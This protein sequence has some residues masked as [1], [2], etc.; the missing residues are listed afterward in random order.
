MSYQY[1]DDGNGT[2]CTRQDMSAL[3]GATFIVVVVCK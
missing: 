2:T 3:V 1:V